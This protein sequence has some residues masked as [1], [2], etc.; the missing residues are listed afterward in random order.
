MVT[1]QRILKIDSLSHYQHSH[2]RTFLLQIVDT[3]STVEFT[4]N[5]TARESTM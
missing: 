2:K 4:P 3:S 1:T 5:T